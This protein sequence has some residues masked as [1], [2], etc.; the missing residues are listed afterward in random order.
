MASPIEIT[1]QN[2]TGRYAINSALS[3]SIEPLL[4]LQGVNFFVR[5]A[6]SKA[7]AKM[8]VRQIPAFCG[9]T[10]LVMEQSTAGLKAE[11]KL[12]FDWC[13]TK[14]TKGPLGEVEQSSRIGST[15]EI[16]FTTITKQ[17][18]AAFLKG[19]VSAWLEDSTGKHIHMVGKSVSDQWTVEEVWGFELI[20]EKRYHTKRWVAINGEKETQ[21]RFVFDY[22]GTL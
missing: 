3:D 4:E 20:D 9:A 12:V 22:I 16:E 8:S 2:L 19:E 15:S 17:E 5:K 21:G 18:H 1:I 11:E 7:S 10:Q 14:V 13:T 6:I